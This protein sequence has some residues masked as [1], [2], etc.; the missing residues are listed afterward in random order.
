MN[1]LAFLCLMNTSFAN[2]EHNFATDSYKITTPDASWSHLD[3]KSKE[4][5]SL[6][7]R[8]KDKKT[9]LTVREFK[10]S[11]KTLKESASS[12][13][14]EYKSYGFSVSKSKPVK[15]N[16]ETYGYQIKAQHKKSGKFFNQYMTIKNKKLLVITCQSSDEDNDFKTCSESLMSFSWNQSL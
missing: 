1:L 5:I 4:E 11:Q 9:S 12:W 8:T 2:T 16:D 10:N 7:L 14:S 13:L 6:A 15:L 3:V